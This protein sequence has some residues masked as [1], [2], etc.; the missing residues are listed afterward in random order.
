MTNSDSIDLLRKDHT[1]LAASLTV[2]TKEVAD[3]KTQAAVRDERDKRFEEN[4]ERTEQSVSDLW[5]LGKWALLAFFG[6]LIAAVV[7]FIVKGGL[8]VPPPTP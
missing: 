1:Q 8:N 4:Q 2:L 5:S 3:L 7:T 6:A